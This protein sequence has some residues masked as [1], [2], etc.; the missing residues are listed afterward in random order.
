MMV[1]LIPSASDSWRAGLSCWAALVWS[2]AA[3]ISISSAWERLW[4]AAQDTAAGRSL[5]LGLPSASCPTP[6]CQILPTA[7]PAPAPAASLSSRS[8]RSAFKGKELKLIW[9][10]GNSG[11]KKR[12]KE[13]ASAPQPGHGVA[14][15]HFCM[16]LPGTVVVI[17]SCLCIFCKEWET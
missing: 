3:R 10:T 4:A 8:L 14:Q 11:D 6:P 1:Y 7:R 15:G 13:T 2:P 9:T 5:Q 16:A 17:P 12:N